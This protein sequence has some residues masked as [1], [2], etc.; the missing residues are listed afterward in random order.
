M[1]WAGWP[2]R[3]PGW[4]ALLEGG[5]VLRVGDAKAN[6]WLPGALRTTLSHW[7]YRPGNQPLPKPQPAHKQR[8]G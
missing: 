5:A 8:R 2:N 7:R 1:I 4:A 3:V 6:V